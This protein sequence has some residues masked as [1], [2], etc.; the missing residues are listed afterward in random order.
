MA[1]G[2]NDPTVPPEQTE[3]LHN[4]LDLDGVPNEFVIVPDAKHGFNREQWND[5]YVKIFAFLKTHGIEGPRTP[6]AAVATSDES[7]H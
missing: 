2:E 5:L 1:Q 4:A 7:A 3:R 6:D